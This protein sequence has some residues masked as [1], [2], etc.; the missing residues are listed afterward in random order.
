MKRAITK[1]LASLLDEPF[2]VHETGV[3]CWCRPLVQRFCPTCTDWTPDGI[4]ELL[5]KECETCHN[6]GVVEVT[7]FEIE[8]FDGTF[9]LMIT[10][11]P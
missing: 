6:E 1:L 11:F 8:R 2:K 9:E 10:H 5:E 7:P 3:R 4:E